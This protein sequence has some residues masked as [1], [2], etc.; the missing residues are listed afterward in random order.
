MTPDAPDILRKILARKAEEIVKRA[1]RVPLKALSHQ[2]EAAPVAR[3]S[4]LPPR[5]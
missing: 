4:L 2:I 3:G 1:R 5:R